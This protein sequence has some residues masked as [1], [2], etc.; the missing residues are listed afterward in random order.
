M[1]R[2]ERKQQQKRSKNLWKRVSS[3]GFLLKTILIGAVFILG[4]V[5]ILNMFIW[6]SDVSKLED[7]APQP[8]IIYDYEGEIAS[9]ISASNIEG[10]SINQIPKDMV[11]AVIATEDQRFYKHSGLSYFGI[12]KAM[13]QNIVSGEIVSGGS[14]ITQQL[15]KNAF[16]TQ[17]R[18][19][20]RKLKELILTKKIERVY[21][22]DE[23]MERYLNQI[24]FGEGA[25]GVQRAAQVYFGKNANQLTLSESAVLAGIIR[26][27]SALSPLKNMDKAI[28]RR[29][30]VLALM[31][32]E[33]YISQNQAE[34]AKEQ[35]II[36]ADKRSKD[37][38][39]KYPHYVDYIID[40]AINKYHLTSNEVLS[41]GLQ[42]YTELNP[43][44]QSAVEEVYKNDNLFPKGQPDQL[45]QSSAVLINPA[46]GGMTALVGGRGEHTF[47]QFN[48][49][50]QL[51][52]QPGSTM[53]PLASYTPALEQGYDIFDM[54]EDKPININ[55][56]QPQNYDSQFHGSVTM[57]DAVIHSY[58]IPAVGL[59]QKIGLE[60]G[61]N[62]VER[63]GIPLNEKDHTLGIALGGMNEGTSPL[64]MAQ[65]FSV[66]PNN[67]VMIEA[68]AIQKIENADGEI[69]G[70]WNKKQTRVIEAS[71]AQKITFMLKG[72][73]KEGTGMKAQI[74]GQDIAGKTGT[75]QLPF[76]NLNGAKDHWFIGYTPNIVGAVWLG[77]DKTDEKHY[78]TSSSSQTA[79]VIFKEILLKSG[80]ALPPKEF[81]LSLLGKKYKDQLEKKKEK[82]EKGQGQEQGNKR[83]ENKP[84]K[85]EHKNKNHGKG[86]GKNKD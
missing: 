8:T 47:R 34:K 3:K 54:L 48:R 42:I 66:F 12:V 49:A 31:K 10:I 55:G 4:C 44:I 13:L 72:V 33:G 56:Y 28:E 77:Y 73:V 64:K 15:A 38:D 17:E 2:I 29:N 60:K 7:P 5:F 69:L 74:E 67:G 9:K 57:Y 83:K 16:L 81:D 40:E 27:P 86:K 36:L 85:K 18:T 25:W 71:I 19:Y 23:I 32:K 52:R 43:S 26:A 11:Q 82:E 39:G 62:A 22:K 53:K 79:T 65:A 58:N 63:F 30:T 20:T 41:G 6:T 75:T 35:A 61:T 45:V 21:S 70:K 59:L 1:G 50:T 14:T 68:H 84:G 76:A 46:T 37:Y 51:K 24:Y 80:E 78:L